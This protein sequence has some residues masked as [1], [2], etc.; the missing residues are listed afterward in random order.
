MKPI[1]KFETYTNARTSNTDVKKM[2]F[3][4]DEHYDHEP[5]S[6]MLIGQLESIIENAQE[7]LSLVQNKETIEDW[8]QSKITIAEDYLTVS[9][10]YYKH[11][12]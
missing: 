12:D 3:E 2:G 4:Y 11:R 9:R 6:H 7:L 8:I 10:D 1:E 5:E